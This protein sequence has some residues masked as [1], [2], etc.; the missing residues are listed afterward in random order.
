MTNCK[1]KMKYGFAGLFSFLFGQQLSAETALYHIHG[2]FTNNTV[3]VFINIGNI[4]AQILN[5]AFEVFGRLEKGQFIYLKTDHSDSVGIWLTGG[6]YELEVEES[7]SVKNITVNDVLRLRLVTAPEAAIQFNAFLINRENLRSQIRDQQLSTDSANS[8]YTQNVLQFE[9]FKK[10]PGLLLELLFQQPAPPVPDFVMQLMDS[11][12]MS[13][14]DAVQEILKSQL[15]IGSLM[16]NFT[17][18]KSDGTRFELYKVQSKFILIDFWASWCVPCRRENKRWANLYNR[19][20]PNLL[21]I[22]SISLDDSKFSWLKA[23]KEDGMRWVN[24]WDQKAW[25]SELPAKYK[26]SSIPFSILLNEK[27][28]VLGASLNPALVEQIIQK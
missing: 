7:K 17:G 19:N 4:K 11:I 25:K 3:S 1:I 16:D 13:M 12:R 10:T 2:K 22:I 9:K 27:F 23:I 26:L 20:P 14:Q 21:S 6:T 24:L 5:N 28:E 15:R 8:L 18:K